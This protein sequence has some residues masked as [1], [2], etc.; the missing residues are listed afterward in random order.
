MA[1]RRLL[2]LLGMAALLVTACGGRSSGSP[3]ASSGSPGASGAVCATTPEPSDGGGSWSGT[4]SPS[5]IPTVIDPGGTIACGPNRIL[6]SFIDPKTNTPVASP[7]R[8]VHLDFYDIGADPAKSV[9][10]A[11]ADFIWAIEGSVGVYEAAVTLPTAGTYGVEFTTQL[12]DAAPEKIRVTTP[13]RA[14]RSVVGVG[15][16]APASENPT[17]ASVGGDVKKIST[18]PNP[19]DAFYQ[20]TVKDALAAKKPFVLVFATPKFCK[21]AQCGP[22]LDRLKPIAAA[23]PSMTFINVEPYQLQE[24]DGQLQ[25]VLTDTTPADLV[26]VEA[27]TQWRLP[28]EPWVFVVDKDGIVQSSLMLIFSDAELEAAIKAVE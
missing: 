9:A 21:S 7:D 27:T 20:T 14:T 3:A 24:V 13:V 15:D 10:S 18:D 12:K 11:D 4:Q 28:S 19:V 23:H 5:V 6:V 22:T 2:A 16:P 25:P 26:P 8:T 1:S 17:L